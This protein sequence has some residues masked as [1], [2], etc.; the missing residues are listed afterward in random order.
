[1]YD[2]QR[3]VVTI[4]L[5]NLDEHLVQYALAASYVLETESMTVVHVL[6]ENPDKEVEYKGA[7]MSKKNMVLAYIDDL[8][9]ANGYHADKHLPYTKQVLTGDPLTEILNFAKKD[10]ADLLIVGR[11]NVA[12]GSANITRKLA[13]KALCSVLAVPEN[14]SAKIKKMLIPIDFSEYSTI[15]LD[16]AFRLAKKIPLE[17]TCLNI[18]TLPNGYLASGKSTEEY[19]EIMKQNAKKRFK[20]FIRPFD[21]DKVKISCRFQLDQ[22]NAAAKIIFNIALVEGADM[23]CIGSRGRTSMAAAFLGSTTEK[24]LL[25][26]FSIPTLVIKSKKQNLGFF[27]ALLKI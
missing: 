3:V 5:T 26:N 18:Y 22:N 10:H 17:I 19:S 1:M 8:L 24:L 2:L 23:I 25:H 20:Q 21:I 11:K 4:D 6:N 15:A 14:S 27:E 13:R 9:M 12:E 16:R 7:L